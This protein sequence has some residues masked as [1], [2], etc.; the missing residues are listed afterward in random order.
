MHIR[1]REEHDFGPLETIARAVHKP[2]RYPLYTPDDNF[3]LIVDPSRRRTGVTRALLDTAEQAALDRGL[4]PILDAV[5]RFAPA[6][7]LYE[8]QGWKRRGT[9]LIDLPNTTTINEHIYTAPG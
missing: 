7:A 4:T 9:A 8:R 3:R 6:I 5:D 1:P 2:D